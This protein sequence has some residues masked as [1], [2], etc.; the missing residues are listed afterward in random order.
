MAG[1]EPAYYHHLEAWENNQVEEEDGEDYDECYADV[2]FVPCR[3]AS[4]MGVALGM[5][6]YTTEETKSA[7][8][9]PEGLAVARRLWRLALSRGGSARSLSAK[10]AVDYKSETGEGEE[11]DAKEEW[12]RIPGQVVAGARV[13]LQNIVAQTE[14]NGQY[15]ELVAEA[16]Q[17]EGRWKVRVDGREK[18]LAL[19]PENLKVVEEEVAAAPEI[20]GVKRKGGADRV[21]VVLRQQG[22]QLEVEYEDGEKAWVGAADVAP[23]EA[24][25]DD[26]VPT[27][28][29]YCR[30]SAKVPRSGS[31][32]AYREGSVE[33]I[34]LDPA[35]RPRLLVSFER[36]PSEWLRLD[37]LRAAEGEAVPMESTPVEKPPAKPAS[38]A[39][40]RKG[41][42]TK[43]D[44]RAGAGAGVSG[45]GAAKA[46]ATAA[47]AKATKARPME[48][49]TAVPGEKRRR[50]Q[51][52]PPAAG[53]AGKEGVEGEEGVSPA[54]AP[55]RSR[56]QG[57]TGP[58]PKA[59]YAP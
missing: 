50:K 33:D 35:G 30:V 12:I 34:R 42:A 44:G 20:V 22:P 16:S 41:A 1:F 4:K 3:T 52:A 55:P 8:E 19:K 43:A 57:G 49:E 54:P 51:P 24:A 48:A 15:G 37:D 18:K 23:L 40:G 9:P 39:G 21:A 46:V 32:S 5:V 58:K 29:L 27:E 28:F 47:K 14:L 10:A 7:T 56:A 38:K 45:G 26:T 25:E 13:Q 53:V 2:V 36:L 6:S 11:G 17:G 31:P 59:G